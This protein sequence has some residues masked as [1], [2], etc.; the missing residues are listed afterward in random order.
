MVFDCQIS[1]YVWCW[2]RTALDWLPWKSYSIYLSL[3]YSTKP[4]LIGPRS[5]RLSDHVQRVSARVWGAGL[6]V[7]LRP[8]WQISLVCIT[9]MICHMI[10]STHTQTH[11][12][13]LCVGLR[14]H[15]H[16]SQVYVIYIIYISHTLI[17]THTHTVRGGT[18]PPLAIQKMVEIRVFVS[19]V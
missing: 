16:I 11:T 2:A 17:N 7:G 5:P 19:L 4:G 3:N 8:H 18:K 13:T 15:W 1:P 12:H 6:C 10:Y 14:P 9:Y